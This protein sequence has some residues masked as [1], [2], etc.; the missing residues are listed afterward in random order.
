MKVA[1]NTVVTLHYTLTDDSGEVLD[2]SAGGEPLGYLHGHGNIIPGLEK[3]LEGSSAGFQSTVTISAAE[4]Y[5]EK[6]PDAVFDAP[7]KHFP[8]DMPLAPGAQVQTQGEHGP[9]T[10][11]VVNVTD[12]SVTLDG[13]HPLAG[14]TL[15]FEVEIVEVRGASEEELAHGHVHGHGG[16]H[17]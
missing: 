14:K 2:S 9:L 4:G 15:H 1:R 10:T 16:H 3:A 13:N 8:Q 12:D 7:R 5:G 11:T 6:N 17:H